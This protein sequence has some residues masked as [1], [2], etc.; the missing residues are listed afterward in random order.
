MKKMNI[1]EV[2]VVEGKHDKQKV[3]SCV[4]ADIIVSSGLHV[5]Q[6]FLDLC[7]ALNKERGI[8]V[9]TDPDGPGEMIR[10]KIVERVGTC[11][12]ASLHVSQSRKNKKVGI[13][14][15]SPEMILD[16]LSRV[17]VFD[18][19]EASLTI[20]ELHELGLSGRID[21]QQLRD[22]LSKAYS[23]PRMNAKRSLKYLNMLGLTKEDIKQT[24][25]SG[26][27]LG[28]NRK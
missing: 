22:K 6:K 19:N 2:I 5:S 3:E 23:I 28:N 24:L 15:A 27:A 16:A 25:E 13:E 7:D 17:A 11:K 10:R 20:Q 18:V 4:N 12:H 1:K 8:I 21:S 14:H 26:E 9:F